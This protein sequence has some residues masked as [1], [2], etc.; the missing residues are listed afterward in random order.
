LDKDAGDAPQFKPLLSAT[1]HN[2][3]V[4]EVS[5]DNAYASAENFEAVA[6]IGELASLPSRAALPEQ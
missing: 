5:A 6:G 3:T 4:N 1:A 2:F